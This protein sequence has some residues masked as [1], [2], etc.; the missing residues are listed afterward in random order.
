VPAEENYEP[1]HPVGK[2]VVTPVGNGKVL[3]H[4]VEQEDVDVAWL[5]ISVE[6]GEEV[7]YREEEVLGID[8]DASPLA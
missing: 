5:A 2:T 8:D 7:K 3:R 6:N 1:R 4:W